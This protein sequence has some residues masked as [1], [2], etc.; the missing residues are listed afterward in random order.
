LEAGLA[1]TSMENTSSVTRSAR[2]GVRRATPLAISSGLFGILYGAAC[3]SLGISPFLAALACI[4]VFSGAVQFAILGMLNE[5]VS[6]ATIAVSSVLICNR[7]I[8]MGVSIADHLRGRSWT[9]RLLAMTVLTDGAWAAT[10]AEKEDVDRFWYFVCAGVWI[11]LLW[12]LGTLSGAVIAGS[13]DRDV[14]LALRFAGILF[15]A[16]LLLLVV[17]NTSMGHGAW[18]ASALTSL[19]GSQFAPLPIAFI[20]GVTVGATIAWLR[21]PEGQADVD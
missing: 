16:L 2:L 6:Y 11:L 9:A 19:A 3:V 14:I 12:V 15:L 1:Q 17:G 13:L 10:I 18:V 5:P 20:A 4:L 7:L 8:L 21:G